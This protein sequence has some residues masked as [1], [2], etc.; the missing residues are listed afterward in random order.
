MCN[1]WSDNQPGS[2]WN[3]KCDWQETDEPV[4]DGNPSN[5][6]IVNQ[7]L[8]GN[9][10]ITGEIFTD[11]ASYI[12]HAGGSTDIEK[13][14]KGVNRDYC[15]K[16]ALDTYKT[17][18]RCTIGGTEQT[19]TFSSKPLD[20]FVGSLYSENDNGFW[21]KNEIL[22]NLD[23]LRNAIYVGKIKSDT[24]HNTNNRTIQRK[25]NSDYFFYYKLNIGVK[26]IYLHLGRYTNTKH[27]YLY[28]A[29]YDF[30]KTLKAS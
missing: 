1:I 8:E 21:L 15:K 7:G 18:V 23:I 12:K 17:T 19:L 13:Q 29:S 2:L 20:H 6:R 4:T 14:C 11:N 5:R 30:P 26:D 10:A 3:C 27:L 22:L 9:P 28:Y 24:D 16:Y 25:K